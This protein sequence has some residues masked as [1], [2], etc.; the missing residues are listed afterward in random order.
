MRVGINASILGGRITGIGTYLVQLLRAFRRT[1]RDAGPE[2]VVFGA[3]DDSLVGSSEN[4]SFVPVGKRLGGVRRILWEQVELPRLCK[5]YSVDVLHCPD[6]ARPFTC[7]VPV[8]NT[9]HDLSYFAEDH[10][11]PVTKRFYKRFLT[12]LAIARSAVLIADSHFTKRE[13]LE[14]FEVDE[15][16]IAV[17]PLGAPDL[18][19]FKARKT[20][21]T[22]FMLFVG[23]LEK[24][25]NIA[26]LV[27]A[28]T[29]VRTKGFRER[30]VLVGQPGFGWSAIQ[31][32]IHESPFKS[33][34]EILG[35]V[36]ST[37][38]KGLYS[39]AD[40]FVFPSNHEGFG[41]PVLEA[42]AA[43][44]PVLCS[45]AGSLTEVAG[46]A[47]EY[48]SSPSSEDIAAA[49]IRVLSSDFR[50]KELVELG[51][52]RVAQF[53]WTKCAEVHI[54]VFRKVASST[55][56]SHETVAVG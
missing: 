54:N 35:F 27:Y 18:G 45:R 12:R 39:S 20:A 17:A 33:D 14:K 11:F 49:M 21:D 37:T 38:L 16:Q 30:L 15:T 24:R 5:S 43:S 7:Q 46:S 22:P 9:I 50:R 51:R 8:V 44:C 4:V 23:T 28:Y 53:S 34:I 55:A 48:S 47:A 41:L 40:L 52:Q 26:N 1:A 36:D 56:V 31:S 42:M 13:I 32:A 2:F 19:E 6:F 3:P 29:L 10:Y 25:K